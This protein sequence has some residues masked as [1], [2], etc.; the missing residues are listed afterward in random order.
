VDFDLLL[1]GFGII[2]ESFP[3]TALVQLTHDEPESARPA[4]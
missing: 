4:R 1:T 3:L 2:L